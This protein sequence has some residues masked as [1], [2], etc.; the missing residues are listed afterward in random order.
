M[1]HTAPALE[2]GQLA[3]APP[4][5]PHALF[6]TPMVHAPNVQ[7]PPLHEVC[8]APP[9][10][11]E[12]L[13]MLVSQLVMAAQ[14]VGWLQPHTP[15]MHAKPFGLPLQLAHRPELP[16]ADA[17]VPP[18]QV[19]A[20][21]LQQPPLHS[22]VELQLLVH[23]CVDTLHAVLAGQSAVTLQPHEP[24]THCEPLELP[25]QLTHT[26]A[27]PQVPA[28][29]PGWQ[30]PPEADEQQPLLHSCVELHAVVHLLVEV[31]HAV[32]SGQSAVPLQPQVPVARQAEPFP[33]PTQL[34]H[35]EPA[36]PQLICVLPG[37]H[38]VPLQQAPLHACE[39]LHEVV[40]ACVVVLHESRFGQSL[41]I[42]QPHAPPL[43]PPMHAL[44]IELPAQL[45]HAPPDEPQLALTNPCVHTPPAQQPPLHAVNP[46]APHDGPHRCV[47]VLHA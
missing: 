36:V 22:C 30:V 2:P 44:P 27:V 40:H 23:W 1:M 41:A 46:L 38:M 14:S 6:E 3:H 39:A 11:P 9:H 5:E 10:E 4:V 24:A 19:P 43:A 16:H 47:V 33:L 31:L 20:A 21:V 42:A 45:T 17:V 37:R 7:Q 18:A 34:M 13:C 26:P 29:L 28:A 32:L 15:E 8:V 25:A 12:H 35:V